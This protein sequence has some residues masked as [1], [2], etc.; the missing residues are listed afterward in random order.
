[1][2]NAQPVRWDFLGKENLIAGHQLN[3]PEILF[4]KIED[5]VI[6]EQINKLGNL[7][8]D[9][10]AIKVELKPE[11]M[12]DDFMK[13]DLRIAEI[14]EAEKVQKSDK[15]LKIQVKIGNIKRQIIA[16]I[17]KT[18]KPEELI[19]K[20]VVVVANLKTAKIMGNES[21]GMI[22]AVEDPEGKLRLLEMPSEMKSGISAK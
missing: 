16:G 12:Y 19:G 22:L 1:M 13:T 17:G 21:Q 15:L 14:T 18:F 3:Q 5:S 20:K 8:E 4:T 2:L 9:K 7:D 6:E 11:I 10:D